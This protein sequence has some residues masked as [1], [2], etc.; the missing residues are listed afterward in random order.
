MKPQSQILKE[1]KALI[2]TVAAAS[3][4]TLSTG[5]FMVNV[6]INNATKSL[7][8]TTINN[9]PEIA[10][11]CKKMREARPGGLIMVTLTSTDEGVGRYTRIIDSDSTL[12]PSEAADQ[13]ARLSQATP[14]K[15]VPFLASPQ[16]DWL[17]NWATL[18]SHYQFSTPDPALLELDPR[19]VDCLRGLFSNTDVLIILNTQ[20]SS[21]RK[22]ISFHQLSECKLTDDGVLIPN[23]EL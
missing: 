23:F 14:L 6:G 19:V 21:E 5:R 10:A 3:Y 9:S 15:T 22:T 2:D 12:T 20:R 11:T 8:S 17:A 4:S 18:I 13:I 1:N 7:I 16:L